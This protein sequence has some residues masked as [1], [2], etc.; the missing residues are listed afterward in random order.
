MLLKIDQHMSP[1]KKWSRELGFHPWIIQ[2]FCKCAFGLYIIMIYNYH[3]Q[4]RENIT[5]NNEINYLMVSAS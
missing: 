4:E 5:E 2:E 1:A 3:Q